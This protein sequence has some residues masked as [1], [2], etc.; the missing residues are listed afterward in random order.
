MFTLLEQIPPLTR[1]YLIELISNMN[2]E[3]HIR[4]VTHLNR[5]SFILDVLNRNDFT[6]ESTEIEYTLDLLEEIANSSP[7]VFR[8]FEMVYSRFL[9][10]YHERK[11]ELPT[12]LH[13]DRLVEICRNMENKVARE[14]LIELLKKFL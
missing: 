4:T 12:A 13:I 3:G 8:K 11:K 10:D 7:F 2:E 6:L 9:E 5:L 1:T 14:K